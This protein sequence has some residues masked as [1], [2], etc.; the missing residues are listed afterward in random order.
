M[1]SGVGVP[2]AAVR[3][4]DAT[5]AVCATVAAIYAPAALVL[6]TPFAVR[7]ALGS[8]LTVVFALDAA[9]PYFVGS[10]A[11]ESNDLRYGGA[12]AHPLRLA[13][14]VVAAVPFLLVGAPLSLHLLWL[15]KLYRVVRLLR[16]WRLFELRRVTLLRLAVFTYW[17]VLLTHWLTV[18][19][20]ALHGR[21]LGTGD[22]HRYVGSLYYCISTLS[23]VGYGDIIPTSGEARGLA[24]VEAILGQFYIAGLVAELIGKRSREAKHESEPLL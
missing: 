3:A 4:W 11:S 22:V 21:V 8:L 16:L 12:R 9:V 2:Q 6:Q 23:T 7:I 13:I 5:L 19:W 10:G 1:K 18:G 20:I 17:L 14:D 24:V 15:L